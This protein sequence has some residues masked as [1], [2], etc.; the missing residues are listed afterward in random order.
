MKI[1]RDGRVLDRLPTTK[2]KRLQ[3]E[4]AFGARMLTGQT[5]VTVLEDVRVGDVLEP[6]YTRHEQNPLFAGHITAARYYLGAS[7][8]IRHERVVVVAARPRAAGAFHVRA[9]PA[10]RASA[11]S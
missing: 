6:A 11:R 2:F 3:R 8:P 1:H 5:L 4:L 9:R 7:C 10:R